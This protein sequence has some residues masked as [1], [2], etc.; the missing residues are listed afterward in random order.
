MTAIPDPAEPGPGLAAIL[1]ELPPDQRHRLLAVRRDWLARIRPEDAAELAAAEAA[2][3][4]VWRAEL[5]TMVEA[6]VLGALA[7]GA[8]A[9]GLPSPGT[10]ARCR[11]RLDRD[12]REAAADLTELRDSRPRPAAPARPGADRAAP[13]G[14][15][16]ERLAR[17]AARLRAARPE[18]FREAR[19]AAPEP[20]TGGGPRAAPDRVAARPG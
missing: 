20:A 12:R 16:P 7:R 18:P 3:A 17:L 4:T 2:V 1:A 15:D 14:L 19:H 6:R 5:L 11:A 9:P 10:L 8:A 13:H